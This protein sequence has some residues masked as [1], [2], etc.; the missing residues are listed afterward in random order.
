MIFI[1]NM[2]RKKTLPLLLDINR[3]GFTFAKSITPE[4]ILEF[5]LGYDFHI[6]QP[7]GKA[8][9]IHH[10]IT[11]LHLTKDSKIWLA[12]CMVSL[13]S[14]TKS[15]NIKAVREGYNLRWD[16]NMENKKWIE[17][18]EIELKDSEKDVL[19]LSSQGYTMCEISE[20]I[21]KSVDSVKGYK[22]VIFEKLNASNITEAISHA[23]QQKLI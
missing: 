4:N 21:H 9:L 10:E 16:Y 12:L 18:V 15:G 19:M 5:T 1:F 13:S 8:V 11:P 3:I 22:R 23:L 20:R 2:L 7:S 17:S 14:Q 6:M